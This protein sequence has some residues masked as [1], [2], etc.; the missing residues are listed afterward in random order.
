MQEPCAILANAKADRVIKLHP[1]VLINISDHYTRASLRPRGSPLRRQEGEEGATGVL[2]GVQRGEVVEIYESFEMV[3]ATDPN[4]GI[5]RFD[6]D[7]LVR[8]KAQCEWWWW[9][10]LLAFFLS[11]FFFSSSF[12]FFSRSFLFFLSQAL[13]TGGGEDGMRFSGPL[14]CSGVRGRRRGDRGIMWQLSLLSSHSS[15]CSLL[16]SAAPRATLA[17]LGT[18]GRNW[19]QLGATGRNW[20]Q[21]GTI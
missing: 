11:F 14:F 18:P 19:A 21:L 6:Q 20:A 9:R 10:A 7:F 13:G 15:L 17:H 2:F 12:F 3:T 4:T 8:K 1:L 5:A 16:L